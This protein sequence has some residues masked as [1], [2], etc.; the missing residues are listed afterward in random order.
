MR[1]VFMGSPEFALPS[2]RRLIESEHRIVGVFT[3]PDRPAGRGRALAS[4]PVKELALEHGL[5]VF[6]PSS[7]ARTFLTAV[8]RVNGGSGGRAS[9]ALM[10]PPPAP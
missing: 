8:S 1:V 9:D 7:A 2:L 5:R 4:P 10:T 3:Q 6:Q